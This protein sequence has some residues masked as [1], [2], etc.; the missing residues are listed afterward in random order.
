MKKFLLF[1]G[2]L[3]AFDVHAQRYELRS[4]DGQLGADI[5]I[6]NGVNVSLNKR[7][8]TVLKFGNI[9]L[10][11]DSKVP[12]DKEFKVEKVIRGSKNEI[13]TAK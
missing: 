13:I 9:S 12:E 2:L 3:L 8:K 4:P 11:T 6:N 7:G 10:E 1:A 5:N